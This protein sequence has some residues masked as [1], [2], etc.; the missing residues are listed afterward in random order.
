MKTF[1]IELVS[2]RNTMIPCTITLPEEQSNMPLF[3]MA[4]GFCATRHENGTYK[5]LAEKLSE[6]GIATIRGDFPGCN[7]SL[8]DHRYNNLENDMDNLD[9][10]LE[11]MCTTYSI[12]P[13]R[14]GMIGYSMGGKIVLHYTKRHPE[15]KTMGLWAPAAM[16]GMSGTHGNLGNIEWLNNC[17]E[18]ARRE[19]VFLYPNTFDD[20]IIPLGVEFFEQCMASRACDYL[21]EFEGN[22]VMVCGS[23]DD[24]IPLETLNEVASHANPNANFLQ[25]VVEGANHGFGA[26]TNEPHQ[27]EE[28]VEVTSRFIIDVL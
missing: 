24:I 1:D 11:H 4:H 20:R 25:H 6:A 2:K 13:N 15:I 10:L 3:L 12:D 21:A 26:W 28:L 22:V 5:M 8:E 9:T 7:D 19:G 16:N 23:K 14:I 27:M 17:L 18:I